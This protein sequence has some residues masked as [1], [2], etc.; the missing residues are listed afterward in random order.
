MTK[1]AGAFAVLL[2][3][4]GAAAAAEP[5]AVADAWIRATPPGAG[6]AAAYMTITSGSTDRLLGATTPVAG[7]VEIHTHAVEAGMS[8]MVRLPE[9]TLPAGEAVRL[10]QGGLHLMLLQIRGPLA[11][12]ATVVMTL[13]FAG[14]GTLELEVPVVDARTGPAAPGPRH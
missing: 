9:L 3:S 8:R 11:P 12:G 1:V 5:P 4:A 2:L 7:A 10:E 14:A 13:Q 6:T